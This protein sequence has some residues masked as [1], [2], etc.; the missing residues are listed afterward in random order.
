VIAALEKLKQVNP[1]IYGDV[2]IDRKLDPLE[3]AKF[4]KMDNDDDG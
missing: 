4:V 2:V 1:K 3:N